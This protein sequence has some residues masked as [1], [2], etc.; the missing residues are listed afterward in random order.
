MVAPGRPTDRPVPDF[1]RLMRSPRARRMLERYRQPI[2]EGPSVPPAPALPRPRGDRGSRHIRYAPAAGPPIAIWGRRDARRPSHEAVSPRPRRRASRRRRP[3]PGLRRPH[4][5]RDPRQLFAEVGELLHYG[6][7][8]V[9]SI[10][11]QACEPADSRRYPGFPCRCPCR[12]TPPRWPVVR[13][14]T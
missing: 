3:Q 11:H 10:G 13:R 5:R 4:F 6:G 7:R 9:V 8:G 2:S 14:S 12:P 1:D